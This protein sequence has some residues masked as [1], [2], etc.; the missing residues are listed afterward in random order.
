MF[1]PCIRASR[2]APS[3]TLPSL[4]PLRFSKILP[5]D[6]AASLKLPK[7]TFPYYRDVLVLRDLGLKLSFKCRLGK[8]TSSV[9]SLAAFD[10]SFPHLTISNSPLRPVGGLPDKPSSIPA[11][12]NSSQQFLSHFLSLLRRQ[13]LFTDLSSRLG[14]PLYFRHGIFRRDLLFYLLYVSKRPVRRV[15]PPPD[16]ASAG[17]LS[18]SGTSCSPSS[19]SPSLLRFLP[20]PQGSPP[21]AALLLLSL[22][23]PAAPSV[24]C[25][26]QD[27]LVVA[28]AVA[29]AA[30]AV[31][32]DGG[33]NVLILLRKALQLIGG[34]N[35]R[36]RRRR[37]RLV[38]LVVWNGMT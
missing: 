37:K 15:H 23:S 33:G 21:L 36:Q 25:Q 27:R 9:P 2:R 7:S 18:A 28:V 11:R 4:T 32:V 26:Q 17:T 22:F 12:L 14:T 5:L 35:N 31:A 30:V 10:T 34:N 38:R 19:P 13:L 3:P 6:Y 16:P 8:T 1:P 20:L 29:V 24:V